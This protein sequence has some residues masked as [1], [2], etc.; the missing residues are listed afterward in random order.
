MYIK[1][2]GKT[3]VFPY[4]LANL[5]S[6]YPNTVFPKQLTEEFLESVGIYKVKESF[7]ENPNLSTNKLLMGNPSYVNGE[8]VVTY[9]E[10]PLSELEL[11]LK[12]H[13]DSKNKRVERD[14]LLKST[15]WYVIRKIETG[16]SIPFEVTTYRQ[17]LRDITLL[18]NFP[19]VDMPTLDKVFVPNEEYFDE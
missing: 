1:I 12:V 16:T 9:T 6:D 2:Q 17:K 4:N 7:P 5:K 3:Q 13:T 18:E 15:D 14:R 11:Q 10:T 8:W 19:Y